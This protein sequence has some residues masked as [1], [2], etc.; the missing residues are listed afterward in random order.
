MWLSGKVNHRKL[1][2]FDAIYKKKVFVNVE[3]YKSN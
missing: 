2:Q 1:E 3:K